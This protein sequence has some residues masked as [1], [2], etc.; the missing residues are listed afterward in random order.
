MQ[1]SQ[2]INRHFTTLKSYNPEL[3]SIKYLGIKR[4][5]AE[6][7]RFITYF[8]RIKVILRQVCLCAIVIGV[9]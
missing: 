7:F 4:K 9:R 1:R 6:K 8:L 2:L 3:L 5:G